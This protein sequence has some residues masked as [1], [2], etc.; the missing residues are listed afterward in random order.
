MDRN[1]FFLLLLAGVTHACIFMTSY[2]VQADNALVVS[3]TCDPRGIPQG[4]QFWGHLGFLLEELTAN[5]PYT[6]QLYFK[7][8]IGG[9][10]APAFGEAHCQPYCSPSS[11]EACLRQLSMDIWG[12]CNNALGAHVEYGDCGIHYECFYF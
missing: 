7:T 10:Y 9:E 8:R 1:A 11:C 3:K 2:K 4:S 6:P 12:I 5:A